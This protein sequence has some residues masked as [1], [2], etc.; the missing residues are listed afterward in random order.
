MSFHLVVKFGKETIQIDIGEDAN[1]EDL[2]SLLEEETGV[3]ARKQKL[4]FKGKVLSPNERLKELGIKHGSK[5]MLL[6]T[7]GTRT[8]VSVCLFLCLSRDSCFEFRVRRH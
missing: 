8:N 6:A 4:L 3:I 1:T 5:L 7:E 2:Q